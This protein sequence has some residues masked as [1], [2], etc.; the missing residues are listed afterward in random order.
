VPGDRGGEGS[1][2]FS[3]GGVVPD[4][5]AKNPAGVFERDPYQQLDNLGTVNSSRRSSTWASLTAV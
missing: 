5:T 4:E 3:G 1:L 2:L